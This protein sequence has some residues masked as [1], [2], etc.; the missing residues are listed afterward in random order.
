MIELKTYK[1][2]QGNKTVLVEVCRKYAHVLFIDSPV[3]VKQ[4]PLDETRYMLPVLQNGKDKSM[5]AVRRQFR[6]IGKRLGI[7]KKAKQFIRRAA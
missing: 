2:E 3:T 4:V 6:T 1:T 5:A 7:T